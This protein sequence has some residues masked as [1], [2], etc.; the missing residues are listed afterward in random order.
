MAEKIVRFECKECDGTGHSRDSYR[1]RVQ[2]YGCEVC[3]GNGFFEEIEDDNEE[4]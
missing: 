4:S 3:D 2:I 1:D